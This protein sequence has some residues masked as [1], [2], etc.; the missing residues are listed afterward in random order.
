MK[1]R[2][3]ARAGAFYEDSDGALRTQIHQCF[4]HQLGPRGIPSVPSATDKGLIGLIVPHAGYT[5]SGP[6]AAHSYYKLASAGP[7]PSVVILGPNHTGY[8]SPVSTMTNGAWSTPLGDVQLD[9]ELAGKIVKRSGL[10]DVEEEAHRNEHSIEVQLPFLQFIFPRLFRFVPIC[11]GLQDLQTSVDVGEAVGDAIGEEG[12]VVIASSDW[13]HYEPQAKAV[14][15]DK[16]ALGAA[17]AMDEK[18]FQRTIEAKRITACG[19][20]PITAMIHAAKILGARNGELLAYHTSG[21]VTGD[22]EAVVGYAA[23]AFTK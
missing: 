4:L 17:L 13:T 7:R 2:P 21:D 22:K 5:Y 9:S 15:R 8:G 6:V 11:M 16:E 20:G 3:P 19:Y 14:A 10:I 23:A 18:G 12:V 1:T